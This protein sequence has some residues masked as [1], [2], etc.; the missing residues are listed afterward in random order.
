MDPDQTL[1]N[2]RQ[3]IEHIDYQIESGN[4]DLLAMGLHVS[5]AVHAFQSLDGWLTKGGFAPQAWSNTEA[6][7]HTPEPQS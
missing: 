2:L 6:G 1:A 5:A 7:N 3:A 4:L